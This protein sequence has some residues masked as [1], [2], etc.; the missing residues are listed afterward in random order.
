MLNMSQLLLAT[1]AHRYPN[2]DHEFHRVRTVF[3]WVVRMQTHRRNRVKL[4]PSKLWTRCWEHFEDRMDV[5]AITLTCRHFRAIG[6]PLIFEHV[7]YTGLPVPGPRM[8]RKQLTKGGFRKLQERLEALQSSP[9]QAHIR[10]CTLVDWAAG[11]TELVVWEL[12]EML[13]ETLAALP[14]L[15]SATCTNMLMKTDHFQK[16][17]SRTGL[18]QIVMK[19][20][21]FSFDDVL[22][23][24]LEDVTLTESRT[25]AKVTGFAGTSFAYAATTILSPEHL[26]TVNLAMPM[27]ISHLLPQLIEL[28]PFHS[29]VSLT[30]SMPFEA[31]SSALARFLERCPSLQQLVLLGPS[32]ADCLATLEPS[33][34]AALVS[35]CGPPS[36][37]AQI[38]PGRPI[39]RWL[40]R[41]VTVTA[42]SADYEIHEHYHDAAEVRAGMAVFDEGAS[43]RVSHVTLYLRSEDQDIAAE[44]RVRFP[45]LQE[46]CIVTGDHDT[47]I[48]PLMHRSPPRRSCISRPRPETDEDNVLSSLDIGEEQCIE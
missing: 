18:R 37:A 31:S 20:C 10:R 16:L 27:T 30:L 42:G 46:L 28:P 7:K 21:T 32:P 17:V 9:L 41:S 44:V 39:S 29:L 48:D 26:R 33:A 11:H 24:R 2:R 19:D 6:Q 15:R 5:Q 45:Q 47:I 40:L 3:G 23:Y 34:L 8:S 14:N 36:S 43:A 25:L 4:L 38:I 12:G 1:I 22:P 35:Y 13:F